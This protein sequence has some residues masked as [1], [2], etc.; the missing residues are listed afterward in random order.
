MPLINKKK[1][2]STLT[3]LLAY[4]IFGSGLENLVLLC[5]GTWSL[6]L[7]T[8]ILICGL[9]GYC[10]MHCELLCMAPGARILLCRYLLICQWMLLLTTEISMAVETCS[11]SIMW[12]GTWSV[13][14]GFDDILFQVQCIQFMRIWNVSKTSSTCICHLCIH[15]THCQSNKGVVSWQCYGAIVLEN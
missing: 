9:A 14:M 13:S 3:K 4:L 15:V 11:A 8:C 12:D 6:A 5:F 1:Y 10:K 7:C 2:H